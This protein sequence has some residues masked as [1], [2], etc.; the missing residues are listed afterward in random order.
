MPVPLA[1]A[2]MMAPGLAGQMLKTQSAQGI[3][4]AV[5][6]A[7]VPLAIGA[8]ALSQ[9]AR[10]YRQELRADTRAMK[11]GKLG[12]SEAQKNEMM[13]A[14][15]QQIQASQQGL[16]DEARRMA[17]AGGFGNSGASNAL[18]KA[19]A[20]ANASAAAQARSGIDMASQQQALARRGEILE[21]NRQQRDH[22][23]DNWLKAVQG[24]NPQGSNA[25]AKFAPDL[26]GL[27]TT[28]GVK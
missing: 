2:A 16:R 13:N 17:A 21:R 22:I 4:K 19:A 14:T 7:G 23:Q 3:T 28:F 25:A 12:Y 8:A 27:N 26:A 15:N 1:A 20:Q 9:P 6:A 18:I 24:F 5:Q 11:A 10:T